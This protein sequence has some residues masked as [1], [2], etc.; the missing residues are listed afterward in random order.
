MTPIFVHGICL[1]CESVV[2][3]TDEGHAIRH[4][5]GNIWDAKECPGSGKLTWYRAEQHWREP[6]RDLA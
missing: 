5:A 1:Q 6:R 2:V 4:P 3:I